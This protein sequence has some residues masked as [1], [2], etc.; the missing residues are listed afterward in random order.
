ML[1]L[2][3]RWLEDKHFVDLLI[4]SGPL[5]QGIHAELEQGHGTLA[6]LSRQRSK[7][8]ERVRALIKLAAKLDDT[9][10]RKARGLFRLLEGLIDVSDDPKAV[11][12]Y[13]ALLGRLFPDGLRVVRLPYIEEGGAAVELD[14]STG[15]DLREQLA[16]VSVGPHNLLEIFESWVEAGH[17]LGKVVRQRAELEA[18]LSR[19]GSESQSVDLRSGRKV[20]TQAVRGLLWALEIKP[21][22]KA[23]VEPV[24]A[25]ILNAVETAERRR[26]GVVEVAEGDDEA[27]FAADPDDELGDEAPDEDQAGSELDEDLYEEEDDAGAMEALGD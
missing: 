25:S 17:A 15:A 8:H 22:L 1:N 24:N 6:K 26:S 14:R 21:A 19:K 11:A 12:R 3:E 9:H 20:W 27:E 23:L 2:T 18:A 5:G 16:A 4:S 13:R 10:D 7:A